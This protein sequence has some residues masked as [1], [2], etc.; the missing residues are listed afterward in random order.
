VARDAAGDLLGYGFPVDRE[1]NCDVCDPLY[2][3]IGVSGEGKVV[4][5]AALDPIASNG[6]L[7]APERFFARFRGTS[8]DE[9]VR[10]I[11][12]YPISPQVDRAT[13]DAVILA[14]AFARRSPGA[15]GA[16]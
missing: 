15:P 5:I 16:P 8:R 7:L 4:G 2:L 13:R 9:E 3:M 11:D 1:T 14:L 10:T 12:R 6:M